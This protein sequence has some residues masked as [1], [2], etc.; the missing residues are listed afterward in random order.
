MYTYKFF[1]TNLSK[2]K[3]FLQNHATKLIS[4]EASRSKLTQVCWKRLLLFIKSNFTISQWKMKITCRELS[5]PIWVTWPFHK[6]TWR[7]QHLQLTTMWFRQTRQA[8]LEVRYQQLKSH[9]MFL[10]GKISLTFNAFYLGIQ[11]RRTWQARMH[12]PMPLSVK[13]FPFCKVVI[14]LFRNLADMDVF[15][16]SDPSKFMDIENGVWT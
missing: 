1:L 11:R 12:T 16:K 6:T 5:W 14:V 7:L 3:L 8:R 4:R 9:Y 2:R 10:A 15:S 13:S